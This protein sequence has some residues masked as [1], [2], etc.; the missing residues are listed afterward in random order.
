MDG[1]ED[2]KRLEVLS[3]YDILDT[4]DDPAFDDLAN[5]AAKVCHAPA[6]LISFVDKDR[7]WVKAQVG[8][9]VKE[10]P[11]NH[12]FADRA[13]HG[14][15]IVVVSDAAKDESLRDNPLVTGEPH[16][17]FFAGQP[18]IDRDG[19]PLGV[20]YVLDRDGH[21]F[22]DEERNALKVL[23][24]EAVMLL[25]LRRE[26]HE[27]RERNERTMAE[28]QQIR[29]R[30]DAEAAQH[31]RIQNELRKR[32][33]QLADAQRITHLGSWEWDLR[34]NHV[35]W[36]AELYR[37]YGLKPGEFEAT[38]AAYLRRVHPEDRLKT[39]HAI[40]TALV[41]KGSFANE[42]R[43]IRKDGKIRDIFSCGE[44]IL[45]D[46]GEATRVVG[47]CLDV[48]E[49]REAEKKLQHSLSLLNATIEA[50]ADGILVVDMN[51]RVVRC[52]RE[53]AEMWHLP[54]EFMSMYDD[55]RLVSLVTD[56]LKDPAAFRKKVESLYA[57]PGA[58]SFD[59][60]E[61]KDGRTFER[62]SCP[63]KIGDKIVGRVWSF[64][65]VTDRTRFLRVLALSEERYRSLIEA[66][67]QIVW[68]AEP[69][70][71]ICEDSPSWRRF[72][73]QT[74]AELKG[75]GWFDAVHPRDR[76]HV[77][78]LWRHAVETGTTYEAEFRI[79]R[80]DSE[81][82]DVSVRGVPVRE[83]DGRIREW[84]GFCVDITDRKHA[85]EMIRHERDFSN[86]LISSLPGI[87]YVLDETGLNLRWNENMEKVSGYSGEE[88]R[89]MRATDFVPEEERALVAERVRKV[90]TTG[91]ADVEL[92][93]LSKSGKKTPFYCT[94]KLL[95]HENGP[96]LVG[97]GIDISARK[98]AEAEI[99]RL[100]SELE[101]R[102]EQRTSE[103]NSANKE[104]ESF[105][106]TTSHD[107]RA[108]IRA[109]IGFARAVREDV[110]DKLDEE[111]R[112]H[113][114]R[115][116]KAGDR[117]MQLIDDLLN[118]SR[119]GKQA[120]L[121]RPVPLAALV[122]EVV[123]QFEPRYKT[124]GARIEVKGRLPRVLGDPTLLQQVITNLVENALTY[125]KREEPLA[126]EISFTRDR[127]SFVI[128]VKD[129]GIGIAPQHHD[130]IFN[131]FERLH[132]DDYPGTGIGLATVKRALEKMGGEVWVESELGGG[133]AFCIRLKAVEGIDNNQRRNAHG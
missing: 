5:L 119:M 32:E 129:N 3:R 96:H 17:K 30:L 55:Q 44:V 133:S 7:E 106:Y 19:V 80:T 35:T 114:D 93:L 82:R 1:E 99:V 84:I 57:T 81:W 54:P 33:R 56:Q 20:L 72:T 41:T 120:I 95:H 9:D 16:A 51:H 45:N 34:T 22:N 59:V 107:L 97:V 91:E 126:V 53:F 39:N 116:I 92:N 125:R 117:M 103:L 78:E 105:T 73:G 109:I 42:E 48:T 66:T 94:G 112:T 36:S 15:D 83:K 88:I 64:R 111:S 118:Y 11:R 74:Y 10:I 77:A 23:G 79:R 75:I 127:N 90:F 76:A 4:P 29:E 70:G 67:A 43:I 31:E 37:I 110:G 6:S 131:V 47:C 130:R 65:D 113:L 71:E 132:T 13:I 89:T 14:R 2:R 40:E 101:K 25:E 123:Q 69:D 121:L 21:D 27:N 68:T 102:V 49:R 122:Q 26:I 52:N 28:L 50:T 87:F 12:A 108:P 128:R 60:L 115:I 61:F 85:S 62:Y 63:Q 24:H 58:A 38:Y 124:A 100:N 104:M 8:A 18:L 98:H 86:A 46:E